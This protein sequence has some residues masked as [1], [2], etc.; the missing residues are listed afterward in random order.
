MLY[1]ASPL[2]DARPRI[3]PLHHRFRNTRWCRDITPLHRSNRNNRSL[4][5]RPPW[6][7]YRP[8]QLRRISRRRI[9][10][11]NAFLALHLRELRMGN[12]NPRLHLHL[13]PHHR[14]HSR[15]LPTSHET[16]LTDE[17]I[18]GSEDFE[19]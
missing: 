1:T 15:P 2:V 9:I 10:S 3:L 14:K 19:R 18:A 11:S 12:Q 13:P 6:L 8:S 7:R 4:L 16:I 17:Y 5:Q